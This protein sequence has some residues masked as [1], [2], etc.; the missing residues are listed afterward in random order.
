[1]TTAP[2]SEKQILINLISDESLG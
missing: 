1:M 2:I